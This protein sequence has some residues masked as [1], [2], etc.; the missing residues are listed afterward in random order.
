MRRP[1]V[2][3]WHPPMTG[4]SVE[5]PLFLDLSAAPPLNSPTA[6]GASWSFLKAGL[7]GCSPPKRLLAGER[8]IV[9]PKIFAHSSHRDSTLIPNTDNLVHSAH[10]PGSANL[11]SRLLQGY[12]SVALSNGS[13]PTRDLV[14][15]NSRI[16]LATHSCT[17]LPAPSC[18]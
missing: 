3:I 4:S 16:D 14:S 6:Y 9:R 5:G 8:G 13:A 1:I 17:A 7:N 2:G 12:P 15:S 10:G 11:G 18:R